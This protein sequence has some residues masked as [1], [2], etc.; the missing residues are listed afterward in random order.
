MLSNNNFKLLVV[1]DELEYQEVLKMM[2]EDK[3][4][5]V[6]AVS[7]GEDALDMLKKE[8]FHIVLT[9]LIMEGIDGLELLRRI[10]NSH[11]DTEVILVTGF[12]SIKNAVNATKEGAFGYFVKGNDPEE[13]FV[14]VDKVKRLSVLKKENKILWDQ[15]H[16]TNYVLN[17]YNKKFMHA[18]NV[19]KKVA[20]SDVSVLLIGES[21]VG[22]E[23]IA[24]YIHKKR[25]SQTGHFIAVNCHAIPENLLEA[26]LFG[27]E[28]GAYTGADEK[29]IGKFEAAH[30]GTLF[31]DEIGEMSVSVQAKL[32]RSVETKLIERVGSNKL[33]NVEVKLI[34][35]TNKNV[36]SEI[37]KGNFRKDLFYRIN[38]ITIEIPPLRERKED[39]QML[40]NHFLTKSKIEQK[41]NIIE[42]EDD[43]MDFLK[44]YDYPGNVRELKNIIERLVVLSE[45]GIIR[46]RDLPD[47]RDS[48]FE[49]KNFNE[50]V[51]PLK[52][53][54]KNLE[55][56]YIRE[57][58]RLSSGNLTEASKQLKISRRHLH[59]K[60]NEYSI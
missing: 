53:K 47:F 26:E 30:K 33:I 59:N 40:I 60:I 51:V 16:N 21:G 56:Q 50:Y 18:L 58:I 29:R 20:A 52:E 32:L 11:S 1:D 55:A 43:V 46:K 42:I 2:F 6:K 57:V 3:G 12:G 23:V 19:A 36:N 49:E 8:E 14:E 25:N 15:Q 9:D 22:K 13:L 38:A 45:D 4:Y 34:S 27:H 54:I 41:K 5:I 17:T 31:L 24:R 10:K 37:A 48:Y 28:K 39:I 7:S 44:S 35:A